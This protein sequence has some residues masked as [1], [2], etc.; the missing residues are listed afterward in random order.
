MSVG[1]YVPTASLVHF[2]TLLALAAPDSFLSVADLVQAV[3]ASRSHFFMNELS[4]APAS[5]FS[6]AVAL[7][8]VVPVVWAVA[9]TANRPA[10]AAAINRRC[11][12]R[13]L[14]VPPPGSNAS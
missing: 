9:P 7:Q 2:L 10:S 4:A 8:V 5:F 12:G 14:Q 11:M 13:L 3:A 6:A 1:V